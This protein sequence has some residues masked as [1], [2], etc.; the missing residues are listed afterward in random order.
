M[1]LTSCPYPLGRRTNNWLLS[2]V[3]PEVTWTIEIDADSPEEAA[4]EAL[5]VHRNPDSWATHFEVR[6]PQGRIQEV[7]FGYPAGASPNGTVY[8]LIPME[9]GMVR[10]VQAFGNRA[11]AEHAEQKWLW[12]RGL[13]EDKDRE[14]ASDWGT[15]IAIWNCEI[16]YS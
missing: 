7:D 8:V 1:R 3:N 13:A 14:R 15:G 5:A 11:A 2:P 10:G 12:E 9:E 6:D 4:R 16:E